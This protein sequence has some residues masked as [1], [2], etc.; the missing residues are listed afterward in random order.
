MSN[1]QKYISIM[2]LLCAFG[3]FEK[4]AFAQTTAFTYQGRF[5][6]STAVQPTTG[7][8]EME[9]KAF[10]APINGNQFATTVSLPA[11]RVISGIFT[12][13]LDYGA[14]TFNG[15]DVFLEISVRPS[16]SANTFA[17]LSPRQQ[18]TSA[19][20]SIQSFNSTNA[21]NATNSSNLGGIS[22][23]QYV[24]TVDSRLTFIAF[25]VKLAYTSKIG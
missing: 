8:Y 19:P 12:V 14:L 2:L 16:G 13:T 10:D 7:L 24:Q 9:F 18:F 21:L 17:V 5:T 23:N 15:T 22:A 4:H 25:V 6:D 20:Y 3:L 1:L 11:V